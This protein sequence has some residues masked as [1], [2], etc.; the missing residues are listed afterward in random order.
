[1]AMSELIEYGFEMN[2]Y[3]PCVCNKITKDGSQLTVLWHVDDLKISC[4]NGWEITKLL[5]YLRKIY[6]NKITVHRGK[7]FTYLGMDLGYSE[8]GVFTVS[9]IPYIDTIIKDFPEEITKSSPC[10]HN[11]NLFRVREE[12]E[13]KFIPED[14]A[15]KFH[16]SVAQ[17][18][19]LQK[20]AKHDIQ[21][22]SSF[23]SSRVKRP[24]ED[25]WGKLRRVIQY[26]KGT[27]SL[28]LRITVD[29]L[30]ES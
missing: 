21:T 19:F 3:D 30:K 14:Q 15:M 16:H 17:L 27:R 29:N 13:A 28:K 12:S 18:V 5:L 1:M 11:Q 8:K 24:D 23:L 22:A 9:M 20:R 7:S 25:D 26:L 10:P 6:G 2:P 4:K